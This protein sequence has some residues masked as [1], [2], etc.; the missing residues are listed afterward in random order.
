MSKSQ[1]KRITKTFKSLKEA[2]NYQNKLYNK[3]NHVKLV[4]SPKIGESGNYT[5]EVG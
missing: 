4:Y 3:Y 2:E 1:L 5:W